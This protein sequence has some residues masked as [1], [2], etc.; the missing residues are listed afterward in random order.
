MCIRDSAITMVA[1]NLDQNKGDLIFNLTFRATSTGS[2]S[3]SLSLN[4]SITT[5]KVYDRVLS[6][7]NLAIEINGSQYE[8]VDR[9]YLL[10][11]EPNPFKSETSLG[12]YLPHDGAIDLSFYDASGR[13][14]Y[15]VNDHF[16]RGINQIV[17]AKND[18]QVSGVVYYH[19]IFEDVYLQKRM[20]IID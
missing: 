19:L 12:F 16:P 2:L 15:H 13:L 20:I 7:Y 17:V 18:L 3:S 14:L 6:G 1:Y 5:A 9:A 4:S 8:E 10:Q 11:N